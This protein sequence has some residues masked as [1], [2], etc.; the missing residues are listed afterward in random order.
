MITP[1]ATTGY[2]IKTIGVGALVAGLF[3]LYNRS[4]L[5]LVICLSVCIAI[6]WGR[7]QSVS[8]HDHT[9]SCP[10]C[11][12]MMRKTE[13]VCAHCYKNLLGSA[14]SPRDHG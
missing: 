9:K 10:L 11:G 1:S 2:I 4:W 13:V 12:N 5:N 14:H 8:E 6:L 7:S 3:L